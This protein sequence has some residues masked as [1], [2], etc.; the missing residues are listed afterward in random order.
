MRTP[1]ARKRQP[2]E[3]A[4]RRSGRTTLADVAAQVGV[5]VNTVSRSLRAPHTVRLDLRQR[6]GRIVDELN[7]VPNRLAGGLAGS[8][9]GM[10]GVIVTSLFNSEFATILDTLQQEL[11]AHGIQVMIGNSAYDPDEELRLVKAMLSWNPAA[12]AIVG[13]D[14]HPRSAEV[15]LQARIP[16]IEF[17]DASDNAL[18]TMIGMDHRQIGRDQGQHL[19]ERG[20]SRL[21]FVGSVRDTDYRARKRLEGTRAY[22]A[23]TLGRALHVEVVSEAGSPALG[24]RLTLSLLKRVPRI[25]GI[26]CN[27][28]I[29]AFGVLRALRALG[30]RV[31]RDVA[32]IGFGDNDAGTCLTPTLTTMRPPRV[33]IGRL[34]ARAILSRIDGGSVE[35]LCLEATLVARESTERVSSRRSRER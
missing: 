19:I 8:H 3:I 25:D 18:D 1:K 11:A 6:I 35:R 14:H 21:A 22:V 10:V 17:W 34:A 7:Y 24:E 2:R 4:L 32:V 12:I 13:T 33:E 5:S 30:R 23:K 28:D 29:V 20:C 15:L 26:V 16:V 27:G 9:T 31:P